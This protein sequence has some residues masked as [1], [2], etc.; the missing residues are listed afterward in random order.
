LH[1]QTRRR[2][3]RHVGRADRHLTPILRRAVDAHP[4]HRVALP[5]RLAAHP[6]A[7]DRVPAR[8][9][10]R[11]THQRSRGSVRQ[12]QRFVRAADLE[13]GIQGRWD[14]RG[15]AAGLE[16][17]VFGVTADVVVA[18]DRAGAVWRGDAGLRAADVV[19]GG[20][21]GGGANVLGGA[22]PVKAG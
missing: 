14:A 13:G 20:V 21:T 7:S 5:R 18:A 10:L 8:E 6:R 15:L 22:A 1:G 16:G 3:A 12:N 19:T 17:R 2:A 9:F 11:T 4:F